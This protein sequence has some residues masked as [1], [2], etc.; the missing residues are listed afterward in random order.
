[1]SS[2]SGGDVAGGAASGAAMGT[3]IMP[4]WGTAIG[5]VLGGIGG[6]LSG[7]SKKKT[8][9]KQQ[10][11]L[12]EALNQYKAGSVDALG[13]KLSADINGKWKFDLGLAG[14]NAALAAT[15]A[16]ILASTTPLKSR[17]EIARDNFNAN[18]IGNMLAARAN[19]AAAMR[20]GMRTNSNIGNISQALARQT[21]NNF[22]QNY[23]NALQNAKNDAVYNA[24]IA[25]NLGSAAYNAA[26][27]INNMQ[28]NLVQQ[29]ATLNPVSMQQYN[30]IANAQSPYSNGQGTADLFGGLGG[31]LSA[32]S[33]NKQ[34]QSNYDALLTAIMQRNNTNSNP[35]L[36][37]LLQNP[38]YIKLGAK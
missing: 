35:Y 30:N 4:G 7:S 16:N 10:Q 23:A 3:S 22:T 36:P 9:K 13:N 15:R 21:A 32:F 2:S 28:N 17:S 12:Q 19:Q 31:M 20:S 26:V 25:S 24:N 29:V 11:M 27:P 5:A 6:Y 34:E 1:M 18:H 38:N 14:K 37:L 8:A 33:Q